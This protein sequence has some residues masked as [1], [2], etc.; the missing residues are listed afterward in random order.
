MKSGSTLQKIATEIARRATAKEDLIVPVTKMKFELADEDKDGRRHPLMVVSGK[1]EPL[2]IKPHAHQQLIEYTKI[3]GDY[4]KTLLADDPELLITNLNKRI[5]RVD[6]NRRLVRILDGKVRAVLSDKYRMF[7]NEDFADAVLPV[8]QDLNLIILSA[9][10]TETRLYFKAV[11]KTIER[12]I[13]TGKGAL[14]DGGHVIFD[15]ISPIITVSN[16]EVGAGALQVETGTLT[17]AC[18]NLCMFGASMRRYHTGKRAELSDD[19][20]ALL[21]DATKRLSDA[22]IWAQT[23]DIIRGAFDAEKFNALAKRLGDSAQDKIEDVE[24]TVKAVTKKYTLNE[25]ERKGI[26][27]HLIQGGDLTKYGLHSA[28]TRASADVEDYDR[29]TFMER[30]GGDVIDL[31]K[32]SWREVTRAAA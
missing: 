23:Q 13:P 18:T 26:L 27:H 2:S 29:A 8:L 15:T 19:T 20:Y 1:D 11:D 7:D 30:L 9:E 14:G 22:A 4:Y 24:E 32:Q 5:R 28:I 31:D 16:S 3:P 6:E 12:D 21:T 10:I 25:G 17:R